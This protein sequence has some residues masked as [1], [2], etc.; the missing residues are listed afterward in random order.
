MVVYPC[1]FWECGSIFWVGEC[2]FLAW[3]IDFLPE[4]SFPEVFSSPDIFF[5]DIF[6]TGNIS[7]PEIVFSGKDCSGNMFPEIFSYPGIS[8][9]K[10]TFRG[11]YFSSREFERGKSSVNFPEKKSVGRNI[12]LTMPH[13]ST[14]VGAQG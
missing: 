6:L 14:F 3:E 4:I 11:K 2:I 1:V 5:P 7:S 13:I 10:K 12:L 8:F 9:Q